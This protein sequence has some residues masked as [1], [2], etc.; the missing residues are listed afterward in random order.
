MHRPSSKNQATESYTLLVF[1]AHRLL[2]H[3]TLGSRV[4]QIERKNTFKG[5]AETWAS[6]TESA[7]D[8]ASCSAHRAE[9]LLEPVTNGTLHPYRAETEGGELD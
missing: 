2:H 1:N 7:L 9:T 6:R 5:R 8:V 3:S 4:L